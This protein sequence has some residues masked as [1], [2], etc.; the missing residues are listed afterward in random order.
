MKNNIIKTSV[1][2][3]E[4]ITCLRAAWFQLIKTIHQ[5][6]TEDARLECA[7]HCTARCCPKPIALKRSES[8]IG[9]V[10]IMLP[11]EMEYILS[12]TNVCSTQFQ[13]AS[14]KLAS[15]FS[16]IDIGYITSAVPCPF[17]T[18]NN[19]CDI[20]NIRPLDCRSFPLIPIFNLDGTLTFRVD[21]ECPSVN[22]FSATYQTRLKKIW[23][24][25][26][27]NLPMN[28][29]ILYNKL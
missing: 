2:E 4:T 22:T 18:Y 21:K 17:L 9:H 19:S 6:L 10:A 27:P 7:T 14:L 15:G 26:L 8:A 13:H 25:L 24:D 12:K 5:S 16:I 20:H 29:R 3:T 28:Y 11:F 1:V 23:E